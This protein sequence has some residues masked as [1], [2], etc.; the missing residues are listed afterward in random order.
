VVVLPNLQLLQ[1]WAKIAAVPTHYRVIDQD[2]AK[3]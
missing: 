1:R 2:I 3:E